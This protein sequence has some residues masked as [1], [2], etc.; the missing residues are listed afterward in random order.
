VNVPVL[1][2]V[3]VSCLIA[4]FGLLYIA[5]ASWAH[6]VGAACLFGFVGLAFRAIVIPALDELAA[7]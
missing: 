3:A 7:G 1:A 2:C 5:N 4:G 6:A